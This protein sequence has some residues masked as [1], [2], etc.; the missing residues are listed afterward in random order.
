MAAHL[1]DN[2]ENNHLRDAMEMTLSNVAQNANWC[3]DEILT[4]L[5]PAATEAVQPHMP[6]IRDQVMR[7]LKQPDQNPNYLKNS[8]LY[9]N[10]MKLYMKC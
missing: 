5:G 4:N 8:G 6:A 9:N 7:I 1:N 3:L 2:D 10:A